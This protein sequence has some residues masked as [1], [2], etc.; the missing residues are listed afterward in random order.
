MGGGNVAHTELGCS[1]VG[2]YLPSM[3]QALGLL[4]S[5]AVN[6]RINQ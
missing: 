1:S 3:P 5:T 6:Q 2:K 4:C